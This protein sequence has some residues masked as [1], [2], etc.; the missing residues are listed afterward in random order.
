[1][2]RTKGFTLI[3]LIVVI[4]IIGVLAAI[5]VPAMIGYIRQAKIR[6]ADEAAT[7]IKNGVN[8]ALSDVLVYSQLSG[9]GWEDFDGS[10]YKDASKGS[11]WTAASG[12]TFTQGSGKYATLE[13]AF[14][15]FVIEYFADFPDTE[16]SAYITEGICV[17]VVLTVDTQ[18]WGA[19]PAGA[20][21]AKDY[22]NGATMDSPSLANA[23]SC[24]NKYDS[25]I[26][27]A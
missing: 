5:L 16:G 22:K 27:A 10:A 11:G 25:S 15:D 13:D 18:Y 7:S 19:Y 24:V 23:K 21:T 20:I 17:A 12:L 8:A 9:S 26:P 2:K 6:T 14:H 1:M 4:A 3:E